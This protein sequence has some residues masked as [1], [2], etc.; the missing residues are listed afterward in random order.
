MEILKKKNNIS[1]KLICLL[2][3]FTDCKILSRHQIQVHIA[4]FV[5]KIFLKYHKFLCYT[6]Q[7]LRLLSP[8][9][10]RRMY[11]PDFSCFTIASGLH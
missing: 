5:V 6:I 8:Y 11:R 10:L 7:Q 4:M 2:E 1:H 9:I 3:F